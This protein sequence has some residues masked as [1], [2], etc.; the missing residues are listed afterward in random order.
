MESKIEK[1]LG[2]KDIKP[3]ALLWSDERPDGAVEFKQGKWGCVMWLVTAAARGKV[4][5]ASRE[6]AGCYGGA[7]GLG[8]GD[9]YER[10]P[11]GKDGFCYFLSVGNMARP[12][13]KEVAERVKPY[14][15]HE[16]YDNFL[17]G[18]RYRKY[19]QLVETFI[20]ELPM[21][22]IPARFVIF[23]PLDTVMLETEKPEV[24]IFFVNPDQLAALVILANY[25]R[26]GNENVFIPYAAGCQ[27]I[28][29][30]PYREKEKKPS[31][32]VVGL[33][34][35][36]ARLYTKRQLGEGHLMTFAAPWEMFLE[37][38]SNV[39]GSFL[40]RP[41]WRHLTSGDGG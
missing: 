18:E 24:V 5:C 22:D 12:G 15:T 20:A 38:E 16:S 3:V 13:G 26:E 10:F 7:V 17:H 21:R 33:T 19:P 8:F 6:T 25:A 41:T 30:Y 14:L 1:A 31:R 37:M 9:V 40:Q 34:D 23:K 27:T 29:I 28:G 32:A 11:G 2:L 36:S 4:A 35:I 39:D